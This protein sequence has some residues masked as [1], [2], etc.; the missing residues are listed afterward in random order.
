MSTVTLM[1]NNL[2]DQ[3]NALEIFQKQIITYQIKFEYVMD[4]LLLNSVKNDINKLENET[5]DVTNKL[6]SISN[7]ID[8]I[9]NMMI[10]VRPQQKPQI[11][12]K[13]YDTVIDGL[14]KLRKVRT[15]KIKKIKKI[16]YD[17]IINGFRKKIID[18]VTNHLL[19]DEDFLNFD[20]VENNESSITNIVEVINRKIKTNIK[21]LDGDDFSLFESIYEYTSLTIIKLEKISK[22]NLYSKNRASLLKIER[23]IDIIMETFYVKYESLKKIHNEKQIKYQQSL[24]KKKEIQK[25][26]VEKFK[27]SLNKESPKIEIDI[28]GSLEEYT[29]EQIRT[30][31]LE[32]DSKRY[33]YD[34]EYKVLYK[35]LFPKLKYGL[36]RDDK[37]TTKELLEEQVQFMKDK[38]LDKV[39]KPKKKLTKKYLWSEIKRMH[40]S[41]YPNTKYG[42]SSKNKISIL[43][44]RYNELSKKLL[45][46]NSSLITE[47]IESKQCDNI[48]IPEISIVKNENI[49]EDEQCDNMT[50]L[51][52]NDFELDYNIDYSSLFNIGENF[53][54]SHA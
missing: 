4:Q 40:N 13:Q 26:E 50:I 37:C 49:I 11:I 33:I 34:F 41:L 46:D 32:K 28:L 43:R 7:D 36:K 35:E 6:V 38:E 52:N 45:K 2:Q 24:N 1:F 53:G 30:G 5:N 29:K 44:E 15:K 54:I 21:I 31:G 47:T 16:D 19:Y 42:L 39:I 22:S 8:I 20:D 51:E 17:A 3:I 14:Y 27:K 23:K 10:E 48:T 25:K 18:N 12:V 9:D